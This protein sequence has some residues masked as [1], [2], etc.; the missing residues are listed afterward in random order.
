MVVECYLTSRQ[1]L[2]IYRWK[3][4]REL[5]IVQTIRGSGTTGYTERVRDALPPPQGGP[6]DKQFLQ[7]SIHFLAILWIA[8]S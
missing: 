6:A 5:G 2:H 7:P 4:L 8:G 1:A 3:S